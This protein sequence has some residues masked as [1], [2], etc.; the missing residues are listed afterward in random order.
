MAAIKRNSL[1]ANM[2][3][4]YHG[5]AVVPISCLLLQQ[6][7]L[8]GEREDGGGLTEKEHIISEIRGGSGL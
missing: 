2:N 7:K 1:S 5:S 6:C 8:Q 4:N 3:H